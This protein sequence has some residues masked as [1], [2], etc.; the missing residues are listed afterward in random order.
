MGGE[1]KSGLTCEKV[2]S[3]LKNEVE[4]LRGV[5]NTLYHDFQ[6]YTDE[7]WEVLRDLQKGQN[8]IAGEEGNDGRLGLLQN[9]MGDLGEKQS[10]IIDQLA[11]LTRVVQET[12]NMRI[13]RGH[14][15]SR[16]SRHP[17]SGVKSESPSSTSSA[18]SPGRPDETQ[19]GDAC[20]HQRKKRR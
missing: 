15:S 9:Q 18:A 1:E 11:A 3:H 8:E 12:F 17:R 10:V 4:Y 14:V 5:V 13:G 16:N 19:D 2:G 6:C 7:S 20:K